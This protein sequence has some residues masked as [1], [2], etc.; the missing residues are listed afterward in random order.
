MAHTRNTVADDMVVTLDYTLTLDDGEEVESTHGDR[1]MSF[2]AGHDQLLPAFEE[3]L[4]GLSVGDELDVTLSAEDGYG[5]YDDEAF[6]E[7]PIDEFPATEKIE[8]G[9]PVGVH[10]ESG[11]VLQAYVAEVRDDAVILDFNHP[12][13]GET[14]HFHVKVLEVRPATPEE[15]AHGHAHE[16][17]HEHA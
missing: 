9:T 1:P 2:V 7:V 5:E 13:A 4:I 12:L 8:V 11:E 3:A 15:I 17:G 16:G 10:D 14:L 6:E